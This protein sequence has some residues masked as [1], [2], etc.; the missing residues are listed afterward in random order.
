MNK[1]TVA[2]YF[3][4]LLNIY[5]IDQSFIVT[6]GAAMH[7]NDSFRKNKKI[8]NTFCHHEQAC[9]MAA[10]AYYRVC[11]K[12]AVVC[13]TAGPG[14]VNAMNGVYGAFVD[15]IPMIVVSGQVR[16]DNISIESV[17]GLRQFGDQEADIVG[18]TKPITKFSVRLKKN[19]DFPSI[20]HHALSLATD[21]RPGPV[22]IDI[23]LDIQGMLINEPDEKDLQVMKITHDYDEPDYIRGKINVLLEELSKSQRPVLVVGNGVR[24]SNKYREFTQIIDK[25]SIPVLPVQ[26]SADLVPNDHPSF[27]GRPG[28]DGDRA[29]NFVQQNADLVI[30]MGARMHV[31]QVGFNWK[32]YAREAKRIMIDVDEKEMI[33]PNLRIDIKIHANLTTFIPQLKKRLDNYTPEQAHVEYLSWSQL[34]LKK[35]PVLQDYHYKN[36]KNT[37]NPYLIMHTLF[38]NFR[39]DEIIATGDGTAYIVSIKT[40][41]INKNSRLFHNKGCASMGYDLPAAIGAWLA[42]KKDRVICITGDGSIMQNIQELQTIVH[43]KMPIKIFVINNDG[44]HSIRQSQSNYF[45]GKEI[46]C[47]PSSGISFPD[48][49]KIS[50]SF[51]IESYNVTT[52]DELK[53]NMSHVLSTSNPTFTEIAVDKNQLFEPRLSS[54]R[55][56][57]GQIVSLPL[58]D[59]APILPR[60]EFEKNMIVKIW[61]SE[62]E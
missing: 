32:T 8:S 61:N 34:R 16:S 5:K 26:N 56:P 12:P 48:F 33:K 27:C 52:I 53:E 55:L 62:D 29:G 42:C 3:Q 36:Q 37:I 58:E 59:M 7:L 41:I 31:R 57:D 40:A 4:K 6:G 10:D 35:Y 60:E 24:F 38:S 47:G 49:Q 2:D 54:K 28:A 9:S 17:P 11:N 46:G 15:S 44:Y 51:G 14:G 1:I 21:G 39:D 30:I 19:D 50:S 20:F 23:P 18:M 13:V 43:N 25:L 45:D 22:W